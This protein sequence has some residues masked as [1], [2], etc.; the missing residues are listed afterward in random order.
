MHR[1]QLEHAQQ[2]HHHHQLHTHTHTPYSERRAPPSHHSITI[3]NVHKSAPWRHACAFRDK[4]SANASRNGSKIV[5]DWLRYWNVL[6]GIYRRTVAVGVDAISRRPNRWS[7]ENI[8]IGSVIAF[9]ICVVR[10]VNTL[11]TK[12]TS[13]DI[14]IQIA[15][16]GLLIDVRCWFFW[17]SAVTSLSKHTIL[18]DI[19][20]RLLLKCSHEPAKYEVFT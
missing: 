13:F 20:H 4:D 2:H 18:F 17:C 11:R 16:R 19:S 7:Q 6:I 9:R 12:S 5:A 8:P 1:V 15:L 3:Q 10:R 14:S